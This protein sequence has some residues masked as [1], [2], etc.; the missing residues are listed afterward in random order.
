MDVLIVGAGKLIHHLGRSFLARG[1]AVTLVVREAAEAEWLARRLKASVLR[2]DGSWPRTLQEAGIARQDVVLAITANDEDNFVVC[3]LAERKFGVPLALALVND[4]DNELTFRELG[5]RA[6]F[7][8]ARLLASLI[9]QRIAS[10]SVVNIYPFGESGQVTLTEIV[11]AK[12][13]PVASRR[14]QEISLPVQSL[15]AGILRAGEAVI[16]RGETALLPGDRLIVAALP[17]AYP[18]VLSIL[19]GE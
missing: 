16:P 13:S 3:Q 10:P 9:E 14:L 2:A 11:V 12:D 6:I 17:E 15:V 8:P 18:G 7:S 5:V 1:Y 4:P 19:T